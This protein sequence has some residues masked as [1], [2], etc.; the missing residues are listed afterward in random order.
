MTFLNNLAYSMGQVRVWQD[1]F[2]AGTFSEYDM[3]AIRC[4]R[5]T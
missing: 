1:G 3:N 4:K 5:A 2:Y